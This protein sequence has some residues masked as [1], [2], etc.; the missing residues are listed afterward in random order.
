V[1][2][3]DPGPHGPHELGR[4]RQVG[5]PVDVEELW[6]GSYLAVVDA[7]PFVEDGGLE[8]NELLGLHLV[9]GVLDV[10]PEDWR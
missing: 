8:T 10:D 1:P 7:S 3:G 5:A 6:P 9:F 4:L 2:A